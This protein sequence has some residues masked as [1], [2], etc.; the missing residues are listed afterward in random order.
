MKNAPLWLACALVGALTPLQ[1]AAQDPAPPAAPAP[2]APTTGGVG[3]FSP[4]V[5]A[6]RLGGPSDL[7]TFERLGSGATL[8]GT[9]VI[10]GGGGKALYG[11]I[12]LGGKG[13]GFDFGESSNGQGAIA[14]S[15]GGGGF[16]LG[17]TV[18]RDLERITWVSA[19][20]GGVGLNMDVTNRR[21]TPIEYGGAIIQPG[22]TATFEGGFIYA[23]LTVGTYWLI[24]DASGGFLLGL[25]VG[26]L[27]R[28]NTQPWQD[29]NGD[30]L[31]NVTRANWNGAFLRLHIGGGGFFLE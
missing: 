6:G 11:D 13:F 15:G 27:F 21:Q 2:L 17:Y 7:S 20:L 28:L 5:M 25:E 18:R 19:G 14:A 24:P 9:A 26:G 23:D 4:G 1:A 30:D 16:E 3:H 8:G 31:T 29:K 22:E 10:L 12:L